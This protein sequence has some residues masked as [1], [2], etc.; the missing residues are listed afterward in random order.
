MKAR[1]KRQMSNRIKVN[2]I[3]K[4]QLIFEEVKK[5]QL[6]EFLKEIEVISNE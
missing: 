5:S 1:L 4:H 3:N 2:E 6:Q